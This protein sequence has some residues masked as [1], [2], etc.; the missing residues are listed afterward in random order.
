MTRAWLS[1]VLLA[2]CGPQEVTLHPLNVP[3]GHAEGVARVSETEVV[4][5]EG[6][7][8]AFDCVTEDGAPCYGLEASVTDPSLAMVERLNLDGD[9]I[10]ELELEQDRL[11]T[12]DTVVY[13][14][15][16]LREGTTTL[17]L[18]HDTG[19]RDVPVTVRAR[20]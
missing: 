6:L 3:P 14:V 9:V 13:L 10:R 18:E 7:A 1:L 17:A 15:V 20:R 16:G 2:A 12:G 11:P 19:H 8:I 5:T 4:L